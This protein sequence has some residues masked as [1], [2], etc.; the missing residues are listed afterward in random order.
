MLP[1]RQVY[2][3][4]DSPEGLF[5]GGNGNL[6]ACQACGVLAIFAW[7]SAL[8]GSTFL[9][10]RVLRILRVPEEEEL[11]GLDASH[12]GGSAYT[13]SFPI[14]VQNNKGTHGELP[15]VNLDMKV[16]GKPNRGQVAS[17]NDLM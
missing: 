9:L 16:N 15:A 8:I 1:P 2:G 12:H 6:L 4:D 11:I 5:Y 17:M 3:R 7:T 14:K 10:L 13:T